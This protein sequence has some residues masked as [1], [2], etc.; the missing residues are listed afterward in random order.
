MNCPEPFRAGRELLALMLF[1]ALIF[2]SP[3]LAILIIST[4]GQT[5]S[6]VEIW[7]TAVFSFIVMV[8]VAY[9]LARM[10]LGLGRKELKI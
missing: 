8:V 9:F 4:K 7:L 2:L 10:A 1:V 3:A 5:S 6:P